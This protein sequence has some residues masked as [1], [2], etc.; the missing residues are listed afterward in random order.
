VP[1]IEMKVGIFNIDKKKCPLGQNM[2][3]LLSYQCLTL[4]PG[5]M[6]LSYSVTVTLHFTCRFSYLNC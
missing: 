1:N 2:F 4:F 6:M 5:D 3:E